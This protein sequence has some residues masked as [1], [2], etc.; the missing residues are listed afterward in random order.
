ML[1]G[2]D[3]AG[4]GVNDG[5]ARP[6][7]ARVEND[8]SP[9]WF[10]GSSNASLLP[11]LRMNDRAIATFVAK[12]HDLFAPVHGRLSV[13]MDAATIDRLWNPSVAAY[14]KGGR[15]DPELRLLRLDTEKAEI[16]LDEKACSPVEAAA[17]RRSKGPV[18]GQDR[19]R[20][21][22]LMPGGRSR[23]GQKQS[24]R[25]PANAVFAAGTGAG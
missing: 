18:Q 21:T 10:F 1:P 14:Y 12:D 23:P 24:S 19:D 15:D 20:F 16:W 4:D 17:R 25:R 22:G 9:I 2:L 7:T 6:M 8:R 3:G 11:L 13:D 5:R